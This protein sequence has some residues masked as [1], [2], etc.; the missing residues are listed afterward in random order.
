[1]QTN[2]AVDSGATILSG[3]TLVV[4]IGGTAIGTVIDSGGT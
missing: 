1:M 3:G 4:T 2:T